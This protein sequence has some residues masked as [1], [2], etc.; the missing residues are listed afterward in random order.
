MIDRL[1][2]Q[3]LIALQLE[4]EGADGDIWAAAEDLA[5]E[6]E[7]IAMLSPRVVH[8]HRHRWAYLE[9]EVTDAVDPAVVRHDELSTLHWYDRAATATARSFPQPH[10]MIRHFRSRPLSRIHGKS[11]SVRPGKVATG[12]RSGG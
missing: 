10:T 11:S 9:A 5:I 12:E 3:E 8:E 4:D 1:T 7:V 6:R 2:R